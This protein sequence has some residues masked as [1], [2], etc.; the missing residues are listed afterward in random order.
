METINTLFASAVARFHERTALLEPG[1]DGGMITL[2]YDALQAR[3]QQLTGYLQER[4]LAKGERV[5]IW[6]ASRIDWMV[7]FLSVLLAGG[8]VVPL[9]VAAVS[10][11]SVTV[12]V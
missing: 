10:P 5:L 2:T 3:V 1:E 4:H 9:D 7:A 8:V 12:T 6:A 11:V